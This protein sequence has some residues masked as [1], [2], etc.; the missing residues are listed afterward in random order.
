[1]D[2][3]KITEIEGYKIIEYPKTN[4]YVIEQIFDE[5][6]CN[7]LINV[8]N[9]KCL[10]KLTYYK[11]Q[12]VKCYISQLENLLEESDELYYS[13]STEELEYRRILNNINTMSKYLKKQYPFDF[14][15]LKL[16]Y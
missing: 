5:K 6:L 8:I 16:H 4:I 15:Y 1:M 13:F 9:L 7:D 14:E 2:N 12:N 11:N 10:N 3:F